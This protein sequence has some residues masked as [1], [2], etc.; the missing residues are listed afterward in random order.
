MSATIPPLSHIVS[1]AL[2]AGFAD[3]VRRLVSGTRWE[4]D[5]RAYALQQAE[6]AAATMLWEM[7]LVAEEAQGVLCDTCR[8]VT[9]EEDAKRYR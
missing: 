5:P 7:H 1:A 9:A 3:D 6:E 2:E 4:N 8:S